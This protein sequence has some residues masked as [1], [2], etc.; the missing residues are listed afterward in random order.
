VLLTLGINNCTH[1]HLAGSLTLTTSSTL[2]GLN[3]FHAHSADNIVLTS[4]SQLQIDSCI[5][6]H[7][8]QQCNVNVAPSIAV[9][10]DEVSISTPI[11]VGQFKMTNIVGVFSTSGKVIGVYIP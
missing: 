3:S 2:Q 4:L 10:A 8:A 6:L 11:V 9:D 5:H 1:G 7:F